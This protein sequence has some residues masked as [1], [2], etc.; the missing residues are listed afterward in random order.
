MIAFLEGA[1]A[2]ISPTT[3]LMDVH[4][5]GYEVNISLNTFDKI[6]HLQKGRL[7][8]YLKIAE[9]EQSLFGFYE[10]TEKQLFL[11][12]ISVS[13]VGAGTARMM[14]SGMQPAELATAIAMGNEKMLEKVKG[15]GGK[16]AKRIILELKDKVG[17]IQLPAGTTKGTTQNNL[18]LDALNALISLGIAKNTAAYAVRKATEQDAAQQDV[19]EIIKLALKNI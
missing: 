2:H 16:T 3:V 4:G 17:K 18:Q 7:L 12:L 1:F 6:Q 14:L 8:T 11:Q 5:V 9:T 19:Q 10:E 13:G 15:I